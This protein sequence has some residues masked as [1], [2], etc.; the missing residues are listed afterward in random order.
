MQMGRQVL[1][2]TILAAFAVL[3]VPLISAGLETGQIATA[4]AP[5]ITKSIALQV[6]D[7]QRT[8]LNATCGPRNMWTQFHWGVSPRVLSQQFSLHTCNNVHMTNQCLL[9]QLPALRT[10]AESGQE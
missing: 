6:R 4:T 5:G 2:L 8:Q 9:A 7:W 1:R 3:A 10:A